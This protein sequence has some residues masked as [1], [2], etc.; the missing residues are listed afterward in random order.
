MDILGLQ[1]TPNGQTEPVLPFNF[2]YYLDACI[3]TQLCHL[4]ATIDNM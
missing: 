4:K 3:N 1:S 2:D